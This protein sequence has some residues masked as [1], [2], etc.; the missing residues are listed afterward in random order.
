MIPRPAAANGNLGSVG[1][2]VLPNVGATQGY[3][4]FEMEPIGI[5]VRVKCTWDLED[6]L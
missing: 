3:Q 6:F 1:H 5:D 2:F 4:T